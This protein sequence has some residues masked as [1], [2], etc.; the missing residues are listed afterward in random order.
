MDNTH[1]ARRTSALRAALISLATTLSGALLVIG[2]VALFAVWS[3]NRAWRDGLAAADGLE[4]IAYRATQTQV[5]FKIG[6]QE[7]KNVLLR[8]E[9]P[10]DLA[11]YRS[12]FDS[13]QASVTEHLAVLAESTRQL[14]LKAASEHVVILVAAHSADLDRYRSALDQALAGDG[15]L[16]LGAATRVDRAVRGID[17]KLEARID[18]LAAE[19]QALATERLANLS[20]E[21]EDRYRTLRAV[22]YV[23]LAVAFL[24]VGVSLFG[25][26]RATRN[27]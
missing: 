17:R 12:A 15:T 25:A 13:R 1:N 21:L 27:I 10:E 22:L 24:L 5:D 2:I 19:T 14:E 4:Q 26:L 23:L 11:F 3:M 7:W 9:N 20:L 16:P 8:G 6:I 18:A